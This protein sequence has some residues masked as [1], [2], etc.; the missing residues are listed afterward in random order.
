MK[1]H[2]YI[3]LFLFVFPLYLSAWNCTDFLT[4]LTNLDWACNSCSIEARVNAFAPESGKV[5]DIYSNRWADYQV[6]F[7]YHYDQNWTLFTAV[8]GYS[9]NGH[10]LGLSH[11][12]NL[13]LLPLSLGLQYSINVLPCLDYYAG[14]GATYSFLHIHDHSQYVH[15]YIDKNTFGGIFKIGALYY[16]C[17]NVFLDIGIDYLYQHFHFKTSHN[18]CSYVQRHNLNLSGFKGGLGLGVRF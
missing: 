12:T 2:L 8:N 14:I 13:R 5:R 4:D 9:R 7:N 18:D 10:S 1:K 17:S 11:C 15:E 6:Q 16:I 3:C